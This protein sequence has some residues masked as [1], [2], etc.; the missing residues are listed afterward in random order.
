MYNAFN[1]RQNY[2]TQSCPIELNI[3]DH[4][5]NLH[6]DRHSLGNIDIKCPN[7]SALHWMDEKL[8]NSSQ[9]KPRFGMCC[10]QGKIKL[11]RLQAPPPLIR[12]LYD[13]NDV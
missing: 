6:F 2:S 4:S 3:D 11:P 7:C 5:Y 12:A 10:L 8:T 13:G 9:V 1:C